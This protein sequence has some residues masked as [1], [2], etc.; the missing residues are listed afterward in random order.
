MY[1][2]LT[3]IVVQKE[4]NMAILNLTKSRLR[5]ELLILYFSNPEKEFY[6]RELEKIMGFSVGNIRR[7]LNRL[8]Q[9]GIFTKQRKGNLLYYSL[10]L[11]SPLYNEV[12]SIVFKTIGIEGVLKEKLTKI[13]GIRLAFIYGSFAKGREMADSDVDLFLI[14]SLNEMDLIEAIKGVEKQ[15]KRIINYTIYRVDEFAEKVKCKDAFI[16]DILKGPRLF[17]IGNQNE[18]ERIY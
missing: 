13:K 15:S 17:L 6:L 4:Y 8:Q 18:L 9:E 5:K 3:T 1:S 12:K 10:N 7:E 14:G 16:H 11:K 2:N